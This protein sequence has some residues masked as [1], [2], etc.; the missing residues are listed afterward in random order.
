M[1]ADGAGCAVWPGI[2]RLGVAGYSWT[3]VVVGSQFGSQLGYPAITRIRRKCSRSAEAVGRSQ[4]RQDPRWPEQIA[5]AG[6]RIYTGAGTA[7]LRWRSL[8]RRRQ[9]S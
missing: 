1:I 3:T 4:E 2:T 6:Y 7:R 8:A 5:D 9:T